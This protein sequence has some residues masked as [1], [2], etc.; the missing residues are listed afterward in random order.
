MVPMIGKWFKR[1]WHNPF[2]NSQQLFCSDAIV[3]MMR[4]SNYPG[5]DGFTAKDSNPEGLLEF[6]NNEK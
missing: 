5:A 2:H 4:A 6:F 1:K 3:D